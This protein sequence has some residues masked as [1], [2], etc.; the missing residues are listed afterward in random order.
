MEVSNIVVITLLVICGLV[1]LVMI[2]T[3]KR[4]IRKRKER[5]AK[6]VKK[7]EPIREERVAIRPTARERGRKKGP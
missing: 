4:S 3:D 5:L 2:F 7:V 1:T 6:I